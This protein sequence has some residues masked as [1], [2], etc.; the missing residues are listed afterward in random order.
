[1]SDVSDLG[2]DSHKTCMTGMDIVCPA[3]AY[4]FY[5]CPGRRQHTWICTGQ[6]SSH[7]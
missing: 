6:T 5:D 2:T 1:M 7:M 3:P 4:R